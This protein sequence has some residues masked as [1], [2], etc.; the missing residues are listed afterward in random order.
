MSLDLLQILSTRE[1][2][3]RFKRF[4]RP[5]ILSR[6]IETIVNDMEKYYGEELEEID[7]EEYRE[8][9]RIVAHPTWTSDKLETFD[10]IFSQLEIHSPSDVAEKIV[11]K[12]VTQDYSARIADI[13]LKGAEGE[14]VN[15]DDVE[16]LLKLHNEET[17]RV[18][19]LDK[20]IVEDDLESIVEGLV[21]TGYEWRMGFLNK[22]IGLLQPEKLICFAARPGIGKTTFL[23]SEASYIVTQIPED[24]YI[25][26]FNNEESGG[27]VKF[28][29]IT[30]TLGIPGDEILSNPVKYKKEYD[31]TPSKR[32]LVINNGSI[33][34]RD[35]EEFC[36]RKPPALVI[37]DQ[38]WKVHGFEKAG[39]KTEQLGSLFRWGRELGKTYKCPVMTVHQIKT[40]GE[41]MKWLTSDLLYFS[42]TDI[43]GEVDSLILMGAAHT[44]GEEDLRFITIGKSKSA[45]GKDVDRSL[46]NGRSVQRILTEEAR[47]E[48]VDC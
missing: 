15:L 44:P 22:S 37:I 19:R 13:A 45:Y 26:W 42:G 23:A 2:Y 33:G 25:L 6:E 14:N 38:L 36:K 1:M 16:N 39:S 10:R 47:Y 9:N 27:A 48:E 29:I 3:D 46:K 21:T 8:W 17:G 20:W 31:A 43:Q 28:R 4:I 32:I 11:E 30:A 34:T 18:A 12:F 40:E 7:W 24:Q 41:G 5:G 35:I